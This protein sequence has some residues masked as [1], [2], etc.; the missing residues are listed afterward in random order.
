MV[1]EGLNGK[2]AVS[3]REIDTY[4]MYYPV[5]DVYFFIE[6]MRAIDRGVKARSKDRVR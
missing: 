5:H 3:L 2:G 1:P 4:L 6:L